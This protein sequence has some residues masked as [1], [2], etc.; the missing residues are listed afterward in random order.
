MK[1]TRISYY[2]TDK[3]GYRYSD[4]GPDG[5]R[6]LQTGV[7]R[8]GRSTWDRSK[9]VYGDLNYTPPGEKSAPKIDTKIIDAIRKFKQVKQTGKFVQT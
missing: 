2:K 9:Y 4:V 3:D 8:Q 5:E 7:S 1:V 6:S